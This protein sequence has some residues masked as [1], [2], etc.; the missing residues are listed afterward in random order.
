MTSY[1]LIN[2]SSTQRPILCRFVEIMHSIAVSKWQQRHRRQTNKL[3]Q[4]LTLTMLFRSPVKTTKTS[5]KDQIIAEAN[6]AVEIAAQNLNVIVLWEKKWW[7]A[8][9]KPSLQQQQKASCRCRQW[10]QIKNCDVTNILFAT[11]DE[12]LI[13]P[14]FKEQQIC[15]RYSGD[16][17]KGN[18][19]ITNFHLFAIQTLGNSSLFKPWPEYQT[20]SLLFK[21]WPRDFEETNKKRNC[22]KAVFFTQQQ[23]N[24]KCVDQ[25]CKS[26]FRNH[27]ILRHIYAHTCRIQIQPSLARTYLEPINMMNYL[28]TCPT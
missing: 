15:S 10:R 4:R 5:L 19:W 13:K 22:K 27:S 26:I 8:A 3:L 9:I 16:L 14:S 21:P 11:N 28:A 1:L 2:G 17:N 23:L 18:I 12:T 24:R 6:N 25:I 20:K 7:K